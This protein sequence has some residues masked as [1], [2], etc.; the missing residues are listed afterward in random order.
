[1]VDT[2]SRRFSELVAQIKGKPRLTESNVADTLREIRIALLEADVALSVVKL[3]ISSIREKA[4]GNQIIGQLSPGQAL[5]GLVNQELVKL[6]KGNNLQPSQGKIKSDDLNCLL[7]AGLQGSGKT[8]TAGKLGYWLKQNCSSKVLLASCDVYRPAAIEQIRILSQSAGVN[9]YDANGCGD[10][11]SIA[12]N[13]K[14]FARQNSYDYLIVDTAG[15]LALDQTMMIE[16]GKI[17]DLIKPS[18]NFFILDA[19]QGQDAINVAKVFGEKLPLTSVIVTKTDGDSRGGS[20]L[21]VRHVVDAPV[22]FVGTGEKISG[23]EEFSAERMAERILGMGDILSLVRDAKT[24]INEGSMQ[25]TLNKVAKRK[26]LN[27]EDFQLQLEQLNKMGGLGAIV[28]KLPISMRNHFNNDLV[29][30]TDLAKASAIIS[31]MTVNEKRYPQTI[32]GSRKRRIARGS[33]TTVQEVNRLLNQFKNIQKVSKNF[34]ESSMLKTILS[35]AGFPAL[36]Q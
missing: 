1:M 22:K 17:H 28:E 10:P 15:R 32:K 2:L 12:V 19:M 34:K 16:L 29:S 6:M 3:F 23:L 30:T 8:T 27:L 9:F 31:S 24:S 20:L 36:R 5:V 11:C 25:A 13:A 18:E 21:S 4:I 7:L 35:K 26:N 33:G 14:K